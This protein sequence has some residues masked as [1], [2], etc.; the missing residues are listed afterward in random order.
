MSTLSLPQQ[1][2]E[3]IEERDDIGRLVGVMY[4]S[5]AV[6]AGGPRILAAV[7]GEH[8]TRHI[9]APLLRWRSEFGWPFDLHLVTVVP[10]CSKEAAERVFVVQ[11][12][13][14]TAVAETLLQEAGMAYTV[15]QIMGHPAAAILARA[16]AL[17]A[18]MIVMGA[19]DQGLV[20]SVL[21][22]SVAREVVASAKVPVTLAR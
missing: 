14:G 15:H 17:D 12:G 18:R 20:E 11:A 1:P 7:A 5:A 4:R 21:L 13:S 6:P 9:I 16:D 10:Y 8:A 22:G 2:G 3:R 19:R